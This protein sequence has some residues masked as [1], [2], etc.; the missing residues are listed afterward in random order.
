MSNTRQVNDFIL[1]GLFVSQGHVSPSSPCWL[2][3]LSC[4]FWAT[5]LFLIHVDSH[6]LPSAQPALPVDASFPLVIIPKM[7]SDFLQG[8]ASIS[9]GG[10]AAQIFFL[11]LMRVAEGVLLALMSYDR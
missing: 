7:V 11:T 5:L 9:F 3:C 2:L 10:C 6:G 1:V 8:E 4:A